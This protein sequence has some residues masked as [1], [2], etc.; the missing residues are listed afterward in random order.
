MRR[1]HIVRK[2][3]KNAHEPEKDAEVTGCLTLDRDDR[4]AHRAWAALAAMLLALGALAAAPAPAAARAPDSFADLAEKLLPTVVNIS[5][6]ATVEVNRGNMFGDI[7][8]GSP[9]DEFL[10]RFEQF[11]DRE[12][13]EKRQQRSLGSG[14]I[15][16]ASGYIV[17]NNHVI[18]GA[19]KITVQMIDGE[20]FEATVVGRDPQT[21]V[22]LLKVD[23]G[24]NLPF[25]KFGDSGAIRVGDWVMAIGN[26]FGLGGSVTTGILSARHREINAGPYDDFLQTDASIN[27][28]NSGGPMFN[29]DGEVIGINTAIFSPT[30][31]NIG[32]GFAIPA[33]QAR[34]V[35]AQL[36]DKGRVDRGWLGVRIQPVTD[37]IAASM[38]LDDT[39]G[40]IVASVNDNSPADKAGFKPGDIIRVFNGVEI[41]SWNKL[42]RVVADTEIGK[43]VPVKVWRDGKEVRLTVV[44]GRLPD[45]P[46]AADEAKPDSGKADPKDRLVL[47]MDL[48]MLDDAV[49]QRF[50]IAADVEGV[51]VANLDRASDAAAKGVRPGDVIAQVRGQSVQS[52]S[53]VADQV[54]A[55]REAKLG[56]VL[57]WVYRD[58]DYFHVAV[59][60]DDTKK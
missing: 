43:K 10:K 48:R 11:G 14:F 16:D 5:T 3:P 46:E 2:K 6:E 26:P 30:G 38:G 28:G 8:P 51:F 17:T 42:P 34:S 18:D 29:M 56:A 4:L 35:I 44:T 60:L 50:E 13:P 36:R 39:K 37:D 40:A 9:L 20:E 32:I 22:A 45:D 54:D 27:R 15:I 57:L 59:K 21:D 53:D 49:R 7:P 47:G 33:N 1:C 12:E 58:G 52:P 23:A 24:K 19:D 25:A 55:A 31:G 41:D